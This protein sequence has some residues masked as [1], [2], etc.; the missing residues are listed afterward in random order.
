MPT[1]DF[2]HLLKTEQQQHFS[3]LTA[4]VHFFYDLS[5][6]P[7][8]R[9]SQP[10]NPY[11][12]PSRD[13]LFSPLHCR[14]NHIV[15]QAQC[16]RLPPR[17]RR[18]TS[19]LRLQAL[20][21]RL[22][23]VRCNAAVNLQTPSALPSIKTLWP[24]PPTFCWSNHSVCQAQCLRSLPWTSHPTSLL[25]ACSCAVL[26]HSQRPVISRGRFA[27]RSTDTSCSQSSVPSEFLVVCLGWWSLLQ[28]KRWFRF[29]SATS[30]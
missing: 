17:T 3:S 23:L 20:C 5:P 11:A 16:L 15:S 24:S 26:L 1:S 10:P 25:I 9:S 29:C 21:R 18:L 30:V 7:I 13:P 8:H 22:P 12:L 19:I 27:S 6:S 2:I 28:I 4:I 14:R